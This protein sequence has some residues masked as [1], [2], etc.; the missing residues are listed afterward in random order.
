MGEVGAIGVEQRPLVATIGATDGGEE[1]IR[2]V[3]EL[4]GIDKFLRDLVE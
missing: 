1:G 2:G 3:R 4:L